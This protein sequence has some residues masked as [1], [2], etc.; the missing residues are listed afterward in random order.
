[1]KEKIKVKVVDKRRKDGWFGT[2]FYITFRIVDDRLASRPVGEQEVSQQNYYDLD[3]GDVVLLSFW[4][5]SDGLWYTR[6]E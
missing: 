6:P 3:V 5:H 2:S 4:K 1:M